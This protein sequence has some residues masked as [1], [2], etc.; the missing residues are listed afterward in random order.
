[1]LLAG[2]LWVLVLSQLILGLAFGLIYYSSL[3]YSMDVGVT[4]AE[5][6][7]IHE[8]VIGAGNCGGPAIA[9]AAL[10]LFPAIPSSGTLAVCLLL[11]CGLGGLF[12]L[13]YQRSVTPSKSL[14]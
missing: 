4:K 10:L 13:R 5:H 8:A 7:G 2:S 1:M 3:F 6:A 9:A 11:L 14:S 12:W